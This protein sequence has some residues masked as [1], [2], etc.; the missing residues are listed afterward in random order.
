MS[1]GRFPGSNCPDSSVS[2]VRFP[3]SN[4]PSLFVGLGNFPGRIDRSLSSSCSRTGGSPQ[5]GRSERMTSLEINLQI[6][7]SHRRLEIWRISNLGSKI[8]EISRLSVC[9]GSK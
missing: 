1:L 4:C 8:K 7:P 9:R 2:L 5:R 6:S 3:D